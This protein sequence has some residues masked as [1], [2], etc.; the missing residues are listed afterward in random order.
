[1]SLVHV[2]KM[3]ADHLYI[4]TS[5]S[6]NDSGPSIYYNFESDKKNGV[7][8][9]YRIVGI[10]SDNSIINRKMFIELS[11]SDSLVVIVWCLIL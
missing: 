7:T 10:I 11:G 6:E 2:Q 4:I 1:M 5:S 8:A 9:G 3:T